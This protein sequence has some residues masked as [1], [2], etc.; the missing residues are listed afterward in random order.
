MTRRK[1]M[2]RFP[3]NWLRER[4]TLLHHTAATVFICVFAMSLHASEDESQLAQRGRHLVELGYT[5]VDGF[6]GD[7]F[8]LE[9]AYTYSYSRNLRIS[10][11]TQLASL[12]VP[13]ADEPGGAEDVNET[14]QGDSSLIIQYDPGA[15]L[16]SNP[17]VPDT[18]G[19]FGS[20]LMPTGDTDRGLSG[21]TW[22]ASIGA[23]WPIIL[24]ET[25][26]AAPTIIYS[27]TF[28]HGDDAVP[29]EELG[30][31]VSLLWLSPVG[32][33]IG[34]EPFISWD[35]ENSEAIDALSL[36]VGKSFRNG[37][38]FDLQ[39]GNR[40]RAENFAKRDDEFLIFKVHWQFGAPPRNL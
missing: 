11:A 33:W 25:F 26:L 4:E 36:I 38:G 2:V 40:R 1:N 7:I 31:G 19:L 20:V 27:S 9:P 29:L 30:V 17:W 8:L 39:W 34:I 22:S 32:A 35:F 14:G 18:I 6:D 16:T 12:E 37:L 21:D 15:N 3:G 13:A 5:R 10:I 24:S 23:G 28:A